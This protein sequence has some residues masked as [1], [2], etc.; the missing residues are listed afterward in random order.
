MIMILHGHSQEKKVSDPVVD[1]NK[2]P[3]F[4]E[5]AIEEIFV[6]GDVV[7]FL[8]VVKHEIKINREVDWDSPRKFDEYL[9]EAD[10]VLHLVD[11]T[12][13]DNGVRMVE[14]TKVEVQEKI[15]EAAE[16]KFQDNHYYEDPFYPMGF[17]NSSDSWIIKKLIIDYIILTRW[18][19]WMDAGVKIGKVAKSIAQILRTYGVISI[20]P[21]IALASTYLRQ[22]LLGLRLSN[23]G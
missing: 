15:V 1:W 13:D 23:I 19:N 5:E 4:D 12:R 8:D 11:D 2:P 3:I 6:E 7:Y 16:K 18:T 17:I 20:D 10:D 14:D 21:S 22:T 9:N